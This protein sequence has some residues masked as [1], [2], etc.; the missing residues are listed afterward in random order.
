[1]QHLGGYAL[2][3]MSEVMRI[4][5]DTRAL[6]FPG[7]V[8]H[9]FPVGASQDEVRQGESAIGWTISASGCASSCF[10]GSTT[11]AGSCARTTSRPP[12]AR[13]APRPPRASPA[14][15]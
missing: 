3:Q 8:G 13:R 4:I 14:A 11:A 7:F 6:L 9:S 1:M 12:T 2:P 15:S 10:A 5:E